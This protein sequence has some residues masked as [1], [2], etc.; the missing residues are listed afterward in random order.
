VVL[1]MYQDSLTTAVKLDSAINLFLNAPSADSLAAARQAWLEAR[2]PYSQT[3]VCR[4]YDG[5]IDQIETKVNSWPI[6]ENY[7]DYVAGNPQAGII[8]DP[9]KFPLLSR[10]L[11]ISL[12]EKEG[13]KNISAGFH[14]VEFLLWGQGTGPTEPGNRPWSDY[15]QDAQN[16]PR[17]RQYLR[18]VSALLVEHLQS[19]V[20]AW[21]QGNARNYRQ[22]FLALDTDAALSDILKGMGSL[23][24]AELEGE[25][26]TVPYE[27]KEKKEEQ[28]CFSDNTRNDLIDDALGIQNIYLGQ[29]LDING[30]QLQGPG[31]RNLLTELDPAFSDKLTA[32]IETAVASVRAIPDS[33]G[34]AVQ[35]ADSSPGR[36]AVRKAMV[37][38]Q[39]QSDMIAQAAKVLSVKLNL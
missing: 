21:S 20:D 6:D 39:T 15:A 22:Q 32:Q 27:T 24:G 8:N 37:A 23:S 5:P 26:L 30:R 31:V 11:I 9:A 38:L 1:A 3:E 16:A 28:D 34:Q 7:I 4:F 12:N 35:G 36:T 29:Y 2:V 33:F 19:V 13:K 17:R 14:A 25:R 10:E 18:I